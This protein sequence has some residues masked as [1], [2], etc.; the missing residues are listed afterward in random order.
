MQIESREF[1]GLHFVHIR[2]TVRFH[3]AITEYSLLVIFKYRKKLIFTDCPNRNEMTN[4]GK[5]GQKISISHPSF[6][7]A[8][9]P[10]LLNMFRQH[11]CWFCSLS[12]SISL[13]LTGQQH[14]L[15]FTVRNNVRRVKMLD[16]KFSHQDKTPLHPPRTIFPP[17]AGLSPGVTSRFRQLTHLSISSCCSHLRARLLKYSL[18]P[19]IYSQFCLYA[20]CMP[21]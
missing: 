1:G 15:L 18:L 21:T 4:T 5:S 19:S 14:C 8:G 16:P 7:A 3:H 2:W 20:V 13:S 11:V 17:S 10:A 9:L 12:L 6:L